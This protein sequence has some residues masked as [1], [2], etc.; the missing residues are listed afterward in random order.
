MKRQVELG[1]DLSRWRVNHTYD[2]GAK[3]KSNDMRQAT[4]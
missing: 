4:V 2:G 1:I 3:V